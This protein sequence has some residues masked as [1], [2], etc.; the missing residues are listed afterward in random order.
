MTFA[1]LSLVILT[2]GGSGILLYFS[3][4]TFG[5]DKDHAKTN[6]WSSTASSAIMYAITL[7]IAIPVVCM[8]PVN[9]AHEATAS[10]DI[11]ISLSMP[12]LF[13]ILSFPLFCSGLC[14]S[15]TLTLSKHQVTVIYFFDLLAAAIGAVSSA[16]LLVLLGGYG[17][18]AF[19]AGLGVVAALAYWNCAGDKNYIKQG[20]FVTTAAAS[21]AALLLYAPWAR[22]ILGTDIISFKDVGQRIIRTDFGGTESTHWN[23][24]ARV[25]VSR[26][27]TSQEAEYW[28]GLSP[29]VMS[30]HIRGRYI[31]LDGGAN[32]RQFK[33]VGELK[34]QDYLGTALWA[35]PYVLQGGT[36]QDSMII[37]GGGGIDVLVAKYFRVPH[38]NVVEMN[39]AIYKILRGEIDDPE[40]AYT[41]WLRS[42]KTSNVQIFNDEARHFSTTKKP[43]SFDV[44][45]ASGVDTLTAIQT[46]G[47]S[48]VEN[49]LYTTEAVNGYVAL[50]KPGGV[51]SLTHWR[52]IGPGTSVRMFITY[53]SCLDAMGIKEPWRHVVVLGTPMWTDA[54]LKV[55]PFTEDELTRIR[56]WAAKSHLTMVFDPSRRDNS[57]IDDLTEAE[58]LYPTI[59]FTDKQTRHNLLERND[60][61]PLPVSDD[62]PYF[63]QLRAN[64][65]SWSWTS[66]PLPLMITT[67]LACLFFMIL[68]I[69]RLGKKQLTA[70][71]IGTAV[72]FALSGFAF[73]LYE[74]A[75]IQVFNIVA[76]G[77]M[78]SLMV[79]LVAVLFGYSLGS[80][81]AARWVKSENLTPW[82]FAM[83]AIGLCLLFVA[84][85]FGAPAV[86][87]Q[88]LPLGLQARL[89][90][91]ASVAMIPSVVVGVVVSSAMNLV[92]ETYGDVV[93]WMWGVSSIF[94]AL[95]SICFIAITQS[96]GISSCLVLVAVMYLVANLLFA[97][98]NLSR[99]IAS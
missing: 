46:G 66:L 61:I 73:L 28:F 22:S 79:V 55:T 62:K 12:L 25:D 54:L 21:I 10:R 84:L 52:R 60:Q 16:P 38:I 71:V 27:G 63:Y 57:E 36:T 40:N 31:L 49:Y 24:I 26:E 43:G 14:I 47:M 29:D 4:K 39:P 42:D 7:A 96:I 58:R 15:K 98:L 17:T 53:L 48:L 74:T 3:P 59:A 19:A 87:K 23:A 18:M 99:Q 34:D 92:R 85:Y 72:Y 86:N 97:K 89:V 64:A 5:F 2:A 41:S 76:G 90:V 13:L 11:W 83:F 75:I 77:P 93:S 95:G 9:P 94:N 65:D 78:Y 91:C 44:I 81:V 88:L 30:R 51:L 70:P 56:A 80:F 33:N 45:Q 35:S 67:F 68:P 50:L 69:M 8:C 37:G 82:F 20:V 32:T 6:R 1:I